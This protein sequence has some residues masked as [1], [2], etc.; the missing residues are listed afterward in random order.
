MFSSA[1]DSWATPQ[2]LF[3]KLNSIFNFD[4]DVC[5]AADTAKCEK[6]YTA[7]DSC[8][9]K[10][11][12]GQV[13]FMN[14]PYGR[15]ISVFIKKAYEESLKGATVVCLLPAR[16]D[17]AYFHDFCTKG[18]IEFLRGRLTFGTDQYWDWLYTQEFV[19]GKKNTL[20]GNTKGKRNAAPFPSMIVTFRP[21]FKQ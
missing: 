5:A 9:N 17:T 21:K 18:D 2:K 12:G 10:D 16:T 19:N 8:L 4:I 14:P 20:F 7:E 6:F 11:W 13:C 1:L 3:D 15:S